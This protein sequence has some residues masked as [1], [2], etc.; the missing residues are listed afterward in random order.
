MKLKRF[1]PLSSLSGNVVRLKQSITIVTIDVEIKEI[2]TFMCNH[3]AKRSTRLLPIAIRIAPLFSIKASGT[4]KA[5][6]NVS[7]HLNTMSQLSTPRDQMIQRPYSP[8]VGSS[9]AGG[10]LRFNGEAAQHEQQ[11]KGNGFVLYCASQLSVSQR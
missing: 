7:C 6:G 4:I 5:S 11:K 3:P 8:A 10:N 1:H 9:S 2:E